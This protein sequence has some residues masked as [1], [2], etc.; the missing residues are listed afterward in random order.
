[1]Q[2]QPPGLFG[3][4]KRGRLKSPPPESYDVLVRP[5]YAAVLFLP[6]LFLLF[7][8]LGNLLVFSVTSTMWPHWR[9]SMYSPYMSF[10]ACRSPL[11]LGHSRN[12]TTVSTPNPLNDPQAGRD[13][14]Y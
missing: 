9:H 3:N 6:G 12:C 1:M 4:A 10:F 13:R 14:V 11:H 2:P 5:G 8:Q 7:S